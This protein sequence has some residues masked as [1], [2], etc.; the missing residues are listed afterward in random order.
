[1]D[2]WITIAE[3]FGIPVLMLGAVSYA[4]IQLFK[5]MAH[6]MMKQIS[7]NQERTESINIKLIDAINQL[8][9]EIKELK[10][11]IEGSKVGQQT[12]IDV[13]SKLSGNGLGKK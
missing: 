13:M 11:G 2:Q 1:M 7:L 3:R 12:I 9:I 8:K 6:T 10:V 5:W 4:L